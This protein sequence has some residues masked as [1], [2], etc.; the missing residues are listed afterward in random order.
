MVCLYPTLQRLG[1]RAVLWGIGSPASG[2]MLGS[3]ESVLLSSNNSQ[4]LQVRQPLLP[5]PVLFALL[6]TQE[7]M[8]T[9]PHQI[10]NL[11]FLSLQNYEPNTFINHLVSHILLQQ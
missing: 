3:R 6:S 9:G 7:K 11:G 5:V 10:S 2:L 1:P 4:L 8:V